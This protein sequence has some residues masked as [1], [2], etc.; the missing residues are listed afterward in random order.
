MD[1]LVSGASGFIGS[2]LVPFLEKQG[3]QIKKLVRFKEKLQEDEIFWNPVSGEVNSD[4]FEDFDAVIHLSGK[5]I[6]TGRWTKKR[7]QEIFL[8]RCRDTW[9]LSQVLLRVHNPPKTFICASAIGIYGDRGNEVL[10][11]ESPAGNSFLATVCKEWEKATAPATEKGIRVVNTRFGAVLGENGG[12]FQKI[13]PVF[14]WGMGGNLGNGKQYLSWIVLKDLISAISFT[15]ETKELKGPV[16]FT[17][18]KPVIFEEF[19][20]KIAERLQRPAFCNL[21]VP[22][23]KL[24]FGKE[25]AQEVFLAST[26]AIP[27]K[28]IQSGYHFQFPDLDSALTFL[29]K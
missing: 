17:A 9:L 15:L 7:K 12:L 1:I 28:L 21:P 19:V 10:T 29:I 26:R 4:H 20:K 24:I 8:T 27:E 16:N 14:K 23:L 11:E 3:H 2:A 18:P 25:M 13:L 22:I 5:N 6:A